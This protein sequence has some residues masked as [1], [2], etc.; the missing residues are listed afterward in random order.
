MREVHQPFSNWCSM[1]ITVSTLH[2][3]HQKTS[4]LYHFLSQLFKVSFIPINN[5]KDIGLLVEPVAYILKIIQVINHNKFIFV[6]SV[7]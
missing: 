1:I 4:L 7:K 2:W 5:F 3:L 6:L